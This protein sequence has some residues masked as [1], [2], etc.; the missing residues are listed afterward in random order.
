MILRLPRFGV[1]TLLPTRW[2]DPAAKIQLRQRISVSPR[3][4]APSFFSEHDPRTHPN[5]RDQ[6]T[7]VRVWHQGDS[8][9]DRRRYDTILLAVAYFLQPEY[10]LQI[11]S[12]NTHTHSRLVYLTLGF[13][14]RQPNTGASSG[15]VSAAME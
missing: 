9:R 2:C 11:H 1:K 13:F 3:P 15:G 12:L 8:D 14:R 4:R 7:G 5:V 10:S 6:V